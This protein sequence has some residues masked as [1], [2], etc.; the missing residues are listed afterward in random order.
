LHQAD[1]AIVTSFAG[2]GA[3]RGWLTAAKPAPTARLQA[4][5]LDLAA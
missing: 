1:Q 3:D 4:S 5:A 2:I